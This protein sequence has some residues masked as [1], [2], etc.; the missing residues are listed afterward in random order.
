MES[1]TP[2]LEVLSYAGEYREQSRIRDFRF[3]DLTPQPFVD[4][5]QIGVGLF[6]GGF[7]VSLF[8]TVLGQGY[9][10]ENRILK[11]RSVIVGNRRDTDIGL[12]P[13]LANGTGRRRPVDI[14]GVDLE[15][16]S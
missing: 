4:L 3:T 11:R 12:S 10:R 6:L 7:R 8:P 13:V 14:V 16:L 1:D 9:F 15:V 5:Y 2:Q